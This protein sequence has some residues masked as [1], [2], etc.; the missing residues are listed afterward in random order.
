M[1][2]QSVRTRLALIWPAV[3]QWPVQN[4]QVESRSRGGGEGEIVC[5]QEE[6]QGYLSNFLKK[7]SDR[8]FTSQG[9][10]FPLSIKRYY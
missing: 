7:G 2:S 10:C 6:S 1:H 9:N 8:K 3:Q 4:P 5:V